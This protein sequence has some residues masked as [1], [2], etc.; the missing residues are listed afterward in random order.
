MAIAMVGNAVAHDVPSDCPVFAASTYQIAPVADAMTPNNAI[1]KHVI[2]FIAILSY[3]PTFRE[4]VPRRAEWFE[5]VTSNIAICARPFRS[6][7]EE[8]ILLPI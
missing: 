8:Q 2:V 5:S 1:E 4:D 3:L 7:A 6:I